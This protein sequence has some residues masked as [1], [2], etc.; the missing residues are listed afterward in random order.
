MATFDARFD[1][2]LPKQNLIGGR[3]LIDQGVDGARII[4]PND[5]WRSIALMRTGRLD[6]VRMPP[7][8]HGALDGRGLAL[9]RAW[10]ESLPGPPVLP[11]PAISSTAGT[12]GEGVM[13]ALQGAPG[14]TIH[15]T[16]DGSAPVAT[17][18][19]YQG[20]LR[21]VGPTMVRA[22]AFQPGFTKSITA[23]QLV[24]AEQ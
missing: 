7:L 9:L 22:R 4:A 19:S 10:I 12:D 16:V 8:P 13:V 18:P 15:Y 11:P 23:Q 20:P 3:V 5:V 6:G 17:D 14:A 2:P 24:N 1:T 21:I